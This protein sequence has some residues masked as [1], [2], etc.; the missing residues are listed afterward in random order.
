MVD[1]YYSSVG[2]N[3]NLILNLSPDTRGLIPDDQVEALSRMA[4]VVHDTFA[5][6]LASGGKLTADNSNAA[7]RPSLAL[8]GNL[9]TWWEA[10]PGHG[11]RTKSLHL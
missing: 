11:C 5:T 1:I 8:D 9:D 6:N 3:G 2:R 7:N 4:Q 10:A